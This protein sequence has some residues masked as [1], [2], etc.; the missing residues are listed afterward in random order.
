MSSL[1]IGEVVDKLKTAKNSNERIDIL[2]NNDS[3]A[4][5]GILRMNYDKSLVLD[6]P[7]GIPP[8]KVNPNPVGFGDTTLKASAKGW[9]VFSKQLCPN[10][11]QS[12]RE[13][14]FINL[15]EMLDSRESKILIDAKDRKLDL[16][17]S[18]RIIED[19]FPNLIKA[20]VVTRHVKQKKSSSKKSTKSQDDKS[21]RDDIDI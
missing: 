11:K 18:K 2:K 13:S 12:K 14:I 19:V 17:L 9:Y 4:L 5:R 3:H 10:I 21:L 20:E 16:G 8:H 6:L 15:L 1:S 7:E